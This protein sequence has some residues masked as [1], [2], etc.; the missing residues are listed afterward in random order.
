MILLYYI[1]DI[2]LV[3]CVFCRR[4]TLICELG[5]SGTLENGEMSPNVQLWASV[6][7]T[8]SRLQ[9]S[10]EIYTAVAKVMIVGR[11]KRTAVRRLSPPTFGLCCVVALFF[12]M[13]DDA[14]GQAQPIP[15]QEQQL[16]PAQPTAP[17]YETLPAVAM[18]YKVIIDP[19]KEDCYFQFVNPGATFYASAQVWI[20]NKRLKWFLTASVLIKY[21]I[22]SLLLTGA[23]RWWWDGWFCRKTSQRADRSPVPVESQFRLPRS[24]VYG[25]LLQCLYW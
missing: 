15:V 10:K 24:R 16:P 12:T 18:D 17:W 20:N 7:L 9:R 8:Q 6:F 11:Q 14:N 21:L 2:T 1:S 22:T 25:R 4:S 13:F 5:E 3:M 19:G 23:E